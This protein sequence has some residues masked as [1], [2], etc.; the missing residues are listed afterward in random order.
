VRYDITQV[1]AFSLVPTKTAKCLSSVGSLITSKAADK[2]SIINA[3]MDTSSRASEM[4]LCTCD[5]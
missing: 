5:E 2:S 3:A 4:S 1:K